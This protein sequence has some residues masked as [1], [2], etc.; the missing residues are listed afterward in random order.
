VNETHSSASGI[1]RRDTWDSLSSSVNTSDASQKL[2]KGSS[3]MKKFLA[4]KA[5]PTRLLGSLERHL[6]ARPAE[7]RSTTV[8]HPSE[9]IKNDFCARSSFFLLK[10]VPSKAERPALKSQAIFDQGHATHDKWQNWLYEMGVLHGSYRCL[11]CTKR[12]EGTS[13]EK[14]EHCG[15]SA[16]KYAEVSLSDPTLRISG[17][18]DGHVRGLGDDFLL[19]VKTIG[20]GTLRYLAPQ[21]MYAADGDFMK[22][23]AQVKAPFGPH[24]LQI[25]VYLELAYRMGIRD[26]DGNPI[27]EAVFI[28]ELKAD[29]SYKEFVRKRDFELVRHVFDKAER[30]VRYVEEDHEPLC[31]NN[32]TGTCSQ[33]E[34]Y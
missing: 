30:I 21:L 20:P 27:D 33:C 32:P 11:A 7:D 8:L 6:M 15:S 18:T 17:H 16:L 24:V 29:N 1:V 26:L 34:P 28:Y 14:C 12:T 3:S 31:S 13:P 5:K 23:W 22:A 19:E 2:A 10:G 9:I 25:Q 4:A